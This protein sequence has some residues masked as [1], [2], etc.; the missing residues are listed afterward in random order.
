MQPPR[1]PA[2]V[3]SDPSVE[4]EMSDEQ[5]A[6]LPAQLRGRPRG[7][8]RRLPRKREVAASRG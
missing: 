1:G 7:R 6:S 3:P 4:T 8:G 5:L 2:D